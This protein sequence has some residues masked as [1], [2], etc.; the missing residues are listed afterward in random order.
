L[1]AV[2]AF[3]PIVGRQPRILILGSLPGVAS[4]AA[5]QYYAHPRNAFWSILAAITGCSADAPYAARVA[6]AKRARL[7]I[8][9]VLAAARRPGSLDSSIE[10]TSVVTNDFNGFLARH[11]SIEL[12]CLNG[13][14]AATLFT[15]HAAPQLDAR[16]GRLPR[17]RLPSTSPAHA[18]LAFARK[19]AAWHKALRT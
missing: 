5:Q 19:R 18:S 14:A 16:A 3:P 10:A 1:T 13:T 12:I 6:A 15:R 9:D 17:V 2:T 4:L 8:W 11:R 7:A